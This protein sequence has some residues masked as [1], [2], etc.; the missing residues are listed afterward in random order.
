MNDT[1]LAY[2]NT[3]FTPVLADEIKISFDLFE[4][5][6]LPDYEIDFI[7][8]FSTA[9]S[10]APDTLQDA[11]LDIL[12]EKIDFILKAHTLVLSDD[13]TIIQKNI[14]LSGLN[15]LQD[16]DS[17]AYIL[18]ILESCLD[19]IE[20]LAEVLSQLTT[21]TATDIITITTAIDDT[22]IVKLKELIYKKEISIN[23][24]VTLS[25]KQLL[26]IDKLKAF[27]SFMDSVPSL[28]VHMVQD[29]ILVGLPLSVYMRYLDDT[30]VN[31]TPTELALHIF[32]LLLITDEGYI[33]PVLAYRSHSNM[34]F[35]EIDSITSVDVQIQKLSQSFDTYLLN[36]K[37]E[38]K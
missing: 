18:P 32:S 8:L 3:I 7:T 25:D 29:G 22:F 16:L 10:Y 24:K 23:D 17:Y 27:K 28:G 26:I 38:S 36:K 37:L 20:K 12:N 4:L 9:E 35:T 34:F 21:L 2:A 30:L 1:F 19:P 33:N 15:L 31:K 14:I 5:F 13:A 6:N 11:F